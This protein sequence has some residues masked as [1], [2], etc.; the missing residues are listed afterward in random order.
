MNLTQLLVIPVRSVQSMKSLWH[1]APA[2]LTGFAMELVR[3]DTSIPR[4]ILLIAVK[5]V[6]TVALMAKMRRY[7]NAQTKA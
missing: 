2:N 4:R 3:W 5:N 1:L 7:Q 6:P